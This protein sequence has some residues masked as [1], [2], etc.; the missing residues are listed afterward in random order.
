MDV[1][2]VKRATRRGANFVTD[3]LASSDDNGQYFTMDGLCYFARV[4]NGRG[5][6]SSEQFPFSVLGYDPETG[7]G[8]AWVSK[9]MGEKHAT[10]HLDSQ[11]R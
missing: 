6:E 8:T 11:S 2:P 9:R 10:R 4:K 7:K 5:E 3:M 1:L